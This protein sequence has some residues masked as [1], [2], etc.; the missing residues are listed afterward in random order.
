MP[1]SKPTR[2][3]RSRIQRGS[4][5]AHRQNRQ[6]ASAEIV[7]YGYPDRAHRI[8]DNNRYNLGPYVTLGFK[9]A[10]DFDITA[11]LDL[12]DAE[13]VYVELGK[14]I[15]GAKKTKPCEPSCYFCRDRDTP[16]P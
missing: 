16:A 9:V 10:A 15:E 2:R 3:P 7:V 11:S 8:P 12:A 1:D 13:R 5:W 14:A 4:F 6:R